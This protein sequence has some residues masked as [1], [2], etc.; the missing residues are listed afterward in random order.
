MD[1]LE[2]MNLTSLGKKLK[3][4]LMKIENDDIITSKFKL[5]YLFYRDLTSP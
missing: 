4:Y 2:E 3:I 1:I 5:N